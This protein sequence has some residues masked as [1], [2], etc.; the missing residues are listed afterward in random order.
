[1]GTRFQIDFPGFRDVH[2]DDLNRRR[3]IAGG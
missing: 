3:K 1:V 2:T